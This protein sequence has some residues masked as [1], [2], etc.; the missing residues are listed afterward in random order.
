LRTRKCL[1][2]SI[3]IEWD[4]KRRL[5]TFINTEF[6]SK[7][8]DRFD[9]PFLSLSEPKALIDERRY[10]IYRYVDQELLLAVASRTEE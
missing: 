8:H 4:S 9:D 5:A 2:L 3:I 1:K 6:L 7:R 10:V